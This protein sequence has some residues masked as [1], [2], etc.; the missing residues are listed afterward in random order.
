MS[1]AGEYFTPEIKAGSFWFEV[2]YFETK[3][4]H[5][6]TA[7]PTTHDIHFWSQHEMSGIFN[8]K[9]SETLAKTEFEKSLWLGQTQ[10]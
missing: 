9:M 6:L 3:T 1:A 2:K 10:N 4:C 7:K 5:M 8:K